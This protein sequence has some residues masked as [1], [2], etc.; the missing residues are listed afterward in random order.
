MLQKYT[1]MKIVKKSRDFS[2]I[3]GNS[4]E[5]LRFLEDSGE[6]FKRFGELENVNLSV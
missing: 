1:T 6:K 4:Y 5:S 3:L 2:G